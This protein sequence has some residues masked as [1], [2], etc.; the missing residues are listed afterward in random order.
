M[1]GQRGQEWDDDYHA[2]SEVGAYFFL[3][4]LCEIVTIGRSNDRHFL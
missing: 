1:E 3:F 2:Y 4:V